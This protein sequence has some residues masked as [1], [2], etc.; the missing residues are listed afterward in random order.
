MAG[1]ALVA[2]L[3]EFCSP[4]FTATQYAL[5]SSL[6]AVGR[7]I[8][9]S[10][11]GLLAEHLGWVKFFSLTTVVTLP[12]LA[13]LVWLWSRTRTGRHSPWPNRNGAAFL[14][15]QR[16]S[17]RTSIAPDDYPNRKGS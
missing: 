7:T 15:S 2:Y 4:A 9:A 5:L 10:S 6:S 1:A 16:S 13:L 12:A 17:V 8:F 14:N 11:G 3:S